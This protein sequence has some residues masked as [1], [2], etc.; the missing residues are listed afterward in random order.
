MRNSVEAFSPGSRFCRATAAAPSTPQHT[1][2]ELAQARDPHLDASRE[3]R[4]LLVTGKSKPLNDAVIGTD[5]GQRPFFEDA[6]L[7]E[8]EYRLRLIFRS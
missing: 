4:Q 7:S 3:G 5:E 6:A 2:V 8:F 1:L